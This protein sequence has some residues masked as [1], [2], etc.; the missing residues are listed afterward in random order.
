MNSTRKAACL[1]QHISKSKTMSGFGLIELM[2]VISIIGILAGFAF[3]SLQSMLLQS[4]RSDA[5]H[6]LKLNESRLTK[7]LTL[8]GSYDDNCRLLTTSKEGL[9]SLQTALT[10]QTWTITAVPVP[11]ESQRNDTD[12]ATISLNHIGVKSSTG[13]GSCW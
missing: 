9:Y 7:C 3:P 2:L 12:C 13:G 11:T 5:H 4:K 10:A 1:K 8:A 6:L